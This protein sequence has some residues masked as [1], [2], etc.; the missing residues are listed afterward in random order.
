MAVM[1]YNK[2]LEGDKWQPGCHA[3]TF[4]GTTLAMV[5]GAKLIQRV[6]TPSFLSDVKRKGDYFKSH[7]ES[8]KKECPIIGDVRGRGLM[9]GIE[10]VDP[11]SKEDM[12]GAKAPSGEISAVLQRTCFENGLI[13]ERGGR[14]G[15]VM[16]CLTALSIDDK[17][18]ERG[19]EIL[20]SSIRSVNKKFA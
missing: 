14:N 1:A 2:D 15:S 4:R 3:G 9:L 16:R 5:A 6:N 13:M 10:I 17:S 19:V 7:F 11:K 20:S 18:L 8:L 12:C